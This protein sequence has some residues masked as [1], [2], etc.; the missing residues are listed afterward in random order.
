MNDAP[1]AKLRRHG[2]LKNGSEGRTRT[3]DTRIMIP[4][5]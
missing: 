3:A 1:S 5:L 4:V 2:G